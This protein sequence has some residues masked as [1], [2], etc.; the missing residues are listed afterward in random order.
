MP[1]K[2]GLARRASLIKRVRQS[3]QPVIVLDAGNTLFSK[4]LNNLNTLSEGRYM[5]AGMN[6][7]GY[8]ALAIGPIEFAL[9][10]DL[11]RQ[12]LSEAKFAAVTVNVT[13]D[14]KAFGQPFAVLDRDGMK[15][16][17]LGLTG[18]G[19]IDDATVQIGDPIAAA[20]AS[21]EQARKQAGLVIALSNLDQEGVQAL[22]RSVP[23]IDLI[24]AAGYYA[25]TDQV[26]WLSGVPIVSCGGLGED[27]GVTGITLNAAGAPVRFDHR[28]VVLDSSYGD[29]Q[30]I[31]ALRAEFQAKYGSGSA[32]V[33]PS[34]Q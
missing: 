16:A 14:G 17:V 7:M 22:A 10:A 3:G 31:S 20:A 24:V 23:G 32:T 28:Q 27:A 9:G 2:G 6:A 5:I 11:L 26:V 1:P 19:K 18:S 25:A 29:D 12:R 15:V 33:T 21:V 4:T 8:D 30:E 13:V 34:P